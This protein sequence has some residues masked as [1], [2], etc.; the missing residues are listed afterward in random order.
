MAAD[1][2]CRGGYTGCTETGP[3]FG[4]LES[5]SRERGALY[6]EKQAPVDH[7]NL[8]ALLSQLTDAYDVKCTVDSMGATV[9]SIL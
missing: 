8:F 2:G 9:Y 3:A 5:P 7:Y 6:T 4:P 1:S